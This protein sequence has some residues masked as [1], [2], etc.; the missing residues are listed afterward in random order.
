MITDGTYAYITLHA[1]SYCGGASN[2]LD[3]VNVHDLP[4]TSLVKVYPMT[5]PE[6]IYRSEMTM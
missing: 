5:R 2:E 3:V 6:A 1:G 4:Q